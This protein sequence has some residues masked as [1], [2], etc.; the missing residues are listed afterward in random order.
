MTEKIPSKILTLVDNDAKK[1]KPKKTGNTGGGGGGG[2]DVVDRFSQQYIIKNGCFHLVKMSRDGAVIEI[3][4]GNF[5][6]WIVSEI[7]RDNGL[8]DS[9]VLII[10]GIRADGRRL[11]P[12]E[13]PAKDFYSPSVNCF[14]SA[15][16]SLV[17]I[18]PGT[19]MLANVKAAIQIYSSRNGDIP[20]STVTA[21]LGWKKINDR[22]H[23][24]TG[25]GA[26]TE[27]GL[28]DDVNVDLGQGNMSRY[29]LPA[30][31]TGEP[32][33]HAINEALVLPGICPNKL[34]IGWALLAAVARAPLSECKPIDFCIWIDG[35]TG[36]RKSSIAAVPLAFFGNFIGRDFPGNGTDTAYALMMKLFQGKAAVFV[37]DEF[38]IA[39]GPIEKNKMVAMVDHI[40]MSTG[41]GSGRGRLN[42]DA[43]IKPAPFNRSLLIMTAEDKIGSQSTFARML[44]LTMAKPDVDIEILTRLQNAAE[45]FPGVTAAYAQWLAPRMDR[46]KLEYPKMVTQSSRTASDA[47]IAKSHS[48][49]PEIYAN[50]ITGLFVFFD[51]LQDA[52]AISS[53]HANVLIGEAETSLQQAFLDQGAY[54]T[55]QDEIERFLQLLRAAFSSGNAHIDCRLNQGPPPSRPFAWGWRDSGTDALGDK[56]LKP[57]GDSVG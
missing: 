10:E 24:L 31:T 49:A 4:L 22:W 46:L 2:A 21:H 53:D 29:Q 44:I 47:G 19:Q 26:I 45:L 1:P 41:N 13:I 33:L 12:V 20:S 39:G 56:I 38:K 55:E 7:V 9:T 25:N 16:G 18:P 30:P 27:A 6:C 15:W 3:F 57:M 5:T 37:A 50:L 40:V 54:Q 34:Y 23:Y 51:F 52:G 36:S 35:V 48:R 32:L 8:M 17:Y 14:N 43:T 11:S 28:V 42:A